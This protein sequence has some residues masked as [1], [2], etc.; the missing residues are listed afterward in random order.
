MQATL[1]FPNR[2]MAELF[3]SAWA[4]YTLQGHDMSATKENGSVSVTVYHIDE[5][6]KEW[7]DNY[8]NSINFK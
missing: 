1:T 6:R 7:L 4:R 5:I 2:A 8:V 3:A